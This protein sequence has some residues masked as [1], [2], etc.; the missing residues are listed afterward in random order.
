M[1]QK[2]TTKSQK[3]YLIKNLQWIDNKFTVGKILTETK[4]ARKYSAQY[5]SH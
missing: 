4:E 3:Y 2:L 1:M 5:A